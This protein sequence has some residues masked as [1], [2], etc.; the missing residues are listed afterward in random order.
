M[1]K[2]KG[3]KYTVAIEV[4]DRNVNIGTLL[5]PL[6]FS[7]IDLPEGSIVVFDHEAKTYPV[8][9]ENKHYT[10]IPLNSIVGILTEN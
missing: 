2:P 5:E 6:T 4:Q 1:I 9:I 8:T 3:L 10:I 7:G